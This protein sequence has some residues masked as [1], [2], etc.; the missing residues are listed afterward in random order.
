VSILRQLFKYVLGQP[1]RRKHQDIGTIPKEFIGRFLPENPK[2]VEAGA[3]IGLDTVEMSMMWDGARIYA[4]E[5]IPWLFK[6]LVSNTKSKSNVTCYPLALSHKSGSI[7]MYVSSGR[8]DGSSS[9]L[10][11]KEHIIEHPDVFFEKEIVVQTTTLDEWAIKNGL[12]AIDFLWLDL[13]GYEL[14]VLEASPRIIKT[15]KVIYTEVSLKE[16]YKGSPLYGEIRHWLEE[17]G[18]RVER[19]ELAWQDAGNVLFVRSS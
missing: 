15:V 13:Q 17:Q 5:P 8:S 19:E 12:Q 18:F 7:N 2:I 9:L 16:L 1:L 10:P 6:K 14:P 4:F 3:H 11:P